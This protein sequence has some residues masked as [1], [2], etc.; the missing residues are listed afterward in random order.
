MNNFQLLLALT[1]KE[2]DLNAQIKTALDQNA[3][4]L[5]INLLKQALQRIHLQLQKLE[6]RHTEEQP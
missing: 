2:A 4:V 6:S 5:E 3:P 1:K